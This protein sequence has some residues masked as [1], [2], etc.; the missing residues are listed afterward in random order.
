MK[1]QYNG[2][3]L[4]MESRVC[5]PYRTPSRQTHADSEPSATAFYSRDKLHGAAGTRSSCCNSRS[6]GVPGTRCDYLYIDGHRRSSAGSPPKYLESIEG[7]RSGS[8]NGEVDASPEA[9]NIKV[10]KS[11]DYQLMDSDRQD[12]L[13]ICGKLKEPPGNEVPS[14]RSEGDTSS[15]NK[16]RR[17]RT[18]FTSYQLEELEKVWFQNRRAKWRKRE[19]YG[20]FHEVRN[21][22]AAAYDIS[23]FP[24]PENYPQIHNNLW[25][26]N[27]T[28]TSTVSSSILSQEPMSSSC[29]TPY[30]HSHG[31]VNAFMGISG[32]PSHHNGIKSLYSLHGFPSSHANH[33]FEPVPESD[34]KTSGLVA[35]RGKPKEPPAFLSWTR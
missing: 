13:R 30:S 23:I 5:L 3:E 29:M 26:S 33:A 27:A 15:K 21:H 10:S 7:G 18:T 4:V 28:N 32:S 1:H 8:L 16:K 14:E 2:G 34:Y 24:K 25:S 35:L 12:P 19:R 22:F 11:I 6:Y 9:L 17:N 31:N 20:K